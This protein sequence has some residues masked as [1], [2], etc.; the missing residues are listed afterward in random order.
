M[1]IDNPHNTMAL[2][3]SRISRATLTRVEGQEL[4]IETWTPSDGLQEFRQS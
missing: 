1:P 2:F 3:T 4:V